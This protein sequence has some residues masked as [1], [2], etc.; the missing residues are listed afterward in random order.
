MFL[1]GAGASHVATSPGCIASIVVAYL[2]RSSSAAICYA[3]LTNTSKHE[4][5]AISYTLSI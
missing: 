1:D 2:F 4:P 3:G 5:E